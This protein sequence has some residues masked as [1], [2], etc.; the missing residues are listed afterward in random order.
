MDVDWEGVIMVEWFE[1]D[2]ALC[3]KIPKWLVKIEVVK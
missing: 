3:L 2:C 1:F